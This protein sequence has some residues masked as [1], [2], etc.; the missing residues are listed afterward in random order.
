MGPA[1][2]VA[3]IVRGIE[4]RETA[5]PVAGASTTTRSYA[6]FFFRKYSRTL[7]RRRRSGSPGVARVK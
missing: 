7:P 5:W 1:G 2:T 6:G 3:R 4:T